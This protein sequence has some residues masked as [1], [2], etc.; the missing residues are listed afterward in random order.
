[1]TPYS[2][3]A[4]HVRS[5][6]PVDMYNLHRFVIAVV[7]AGTIAL[8]LTGCGPK[9]EVTPEPEAP[10]AEKVLTLEQ[11]HE[12]A[13][14]YLDEGRVGDAAGHYREILKA[15]PDDFEANLNL[16]IALQTME[17]AKYVNERDYT[18]I[19]RNFLAARDLGWNDARPHF[20]LGALEFGA[21]NYSAAIGHLSSARNVDHA[22]EA[23]H[24]MLGISMIKTGDG[25]AGRDEL[26]RALEI[27]PDNQAANFELGKFHEK[28]NNNGSA[29]T[30]LEKALRANP[31][32]DMATYVLERVYYEEGLY[33]K[34]E[35]TCRQFLKFHPDDIQSLE[36]LGWIYRH[37]ERT[38]E[39]LEV[40]SRLT[41]IRPD[42]TGYWSPLIQHH[43]DNSNY[44]EARDMLE[45]CLG[46]NPYYAYGNV[47]YGQV[48]MHYGDESRRTGSTN[49]ALEL[50]TQAREHFQKA[51]IDD[52]YKASASQLIDHVDSLIRSTSRR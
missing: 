26:E 33:D 7:V 24:E 8:G 22:N 28:E 50:Y 35:K 16:G 11:R 46:H 41:R 40:Y 49:Q 25:E 52:R 39:M 51:K 42:D 2:I 47:R 14:V 10:P 21:G 29:M 9:P 44:S 31:N 18:E 5:I 48:L 4:S 15:N 43:M 38:A 37:Q 12:L 13:R 32:L 27:N 45:E 19:R 3:I 20:H 30:H 17:D 36:I 6:H 23:V 34:A 1:V